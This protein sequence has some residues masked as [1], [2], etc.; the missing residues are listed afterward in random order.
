MRAFFEE[1][2]IA[3]EIQARWREAAGELRPEP[4][5]DY[6]EF[7]RDD[8]EPLLVGDRFLVV[9][10]WLSTATPAGRFRLEVEASTAFGTGRHE[11]T[12]LC[13]QALEKHLK[14]GDIVL[15]VGC[16]SGILMAAAEMLGAGQTFGC[17]ISFDALT[18]ARL[19]AHAPLFV[20]SA[21]AVSEGLA[22]VTL[23]NIS[24]RVVDR[25]AAELK[26]VTKPGSLVILAGFIRE[27]QPKRFRFEELL[28]QGEWQCWICR[29]EE[30]DAAALGEDPPAGSHAERWWL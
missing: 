3:S 7:E 22:D 18:I 10:P 8:W 2:A 12:Q 30:I 23:A 29:P 24:A 1:Q 28:E 20:G 19:H 9:P 17:D 14:Y 21:D 5:T 13:L 25:L 6:G 11:S 4:V 27:N 26:R 15:D 16:G